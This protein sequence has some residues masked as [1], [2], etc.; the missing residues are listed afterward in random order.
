MITTGYPF[1][2][3]TKTEIVDLANGRS[4]RDLAEFPVEILGAVGA[5]LQ[6]TPVVC[7]GSSSSFE[8]QKICYGF[9]N[10]R[11]QEYPS[12]KEERSYA[13]GVVYERE[14]HVFGGSTIQKTSEIV[15]ENGEIV[16]GP[17]LPTAVQKHAI[18]FVNQTV[19]ILSGGVISANSASSQTFYY[20]H[21]TK[22]FTSG[23]TLLEGRRYHGSATIVDKVTKS[24]IPLV[25]GGYNSDWDE[26][27]STELLI[28]GHWQKGTI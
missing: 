28:N 14:W 11:W 9:T 6:G 20:N 10:G 2:S 17:A 7:G 15:N 5:N 27:N 13:A 25:T 8:P 19:S 12:L 22:I 21:L 3:A 24:K 18:T 4:C 26:M 1:S 16:D 23:P